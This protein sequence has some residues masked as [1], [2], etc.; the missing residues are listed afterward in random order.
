M[1]SQKYLQQITAALEKAVETSRGDD[2]GWVADYIPELTNVNTNYVSACIQL[3]DGEQLCSGDSP[4]YRFTLQSVSKLVLLTGLIEE[5]GP[6]RVF[7]WIK[8]EPSGQP[9]AAIGHLDRYGP[10]PSNPLINA[11][12][13]CLSGRIPGNPQEQLEWVE[14]WTT[15]L[16]N[17]ALT[18]SQA[19]YDSEFSSADRNRSLAYLMKSTGVITRDVEEVLV[20]YL[21][22]CSYEVNIQQAAYLPMLL[23]NG[24]LTPQGKR[25]ISEQTSNRVVSIMAT[26][27]LYDESGSHLVHIG[28]PAKS[29]VS[30]LIVA[31]ATGRG[32]VAVMSPL[33]NTKGTSIRGHFILSELSKALGWHFATP[34]GYARIDS[35]LHRNDDYY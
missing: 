31:V 19:V 8:A 15:R 12:A 2:K 23:A 13:I 22:L 28:L 25:I 20:P 18:F 10:V 33:L 34:W 26:C 30:G 32:G 21:T 24:G 17:G 11:G 7:S 6:D 5:F 14:N 4:N 1:D 9:F 29:G 27:G 16:F 3:S 35:M